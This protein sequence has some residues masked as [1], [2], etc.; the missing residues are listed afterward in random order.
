MY[1]VAGSL[2]FDV[3]FERPYLGDR[4]R[5]YVY[6][7]NKLYHHGNVPRPKWLPRMRAGPLKLY[8]VGVVSGW[9]CACWNRFML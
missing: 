2:T 8:Y 6:Q 7:E 4:D 5:T 1:V 3:Q 9:S